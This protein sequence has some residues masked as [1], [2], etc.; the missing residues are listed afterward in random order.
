MEGLNQGNLELLKNYKDY[1]FEFFNLFNERLEQKEI[2]RLLGEEF[3]E[4]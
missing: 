4:Y 2:E 1:S 3:I